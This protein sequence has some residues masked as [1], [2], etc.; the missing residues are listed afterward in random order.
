[1]CFVGG[2]CT[3]GP[4]K[5]VGRERSE[6]MRSHLDIGKGNA[7]HLKEATK[8]Y[9]DLSKRSAASCHIVDVFACSLDQVGL[10]EMRCL[11]EKTGGMSVLADSFGQSVFKESLRRM[12]DRHD[13]EVPVDGGHLK[14]GFAGTVE[15]LTSREFKVSGAIGPV[16]P[17]HAPCRS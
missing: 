1:M 3:E 8:F 11:V 7:P 12:F 6:D 14:M 16:C 4:G 17:S 9:D 13:D 2:P 5:V 10:M 15:V